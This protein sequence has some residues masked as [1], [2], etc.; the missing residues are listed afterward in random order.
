LRC[1]GPRP[2]TELLAEA[3]P[4]DAHRILAG[5][6]PVLCTTDEAELA[7]VAGATAGNR[8]YVAAMTATDPYL[9]VIGAG[10]HPELVALATTMVRRCGLGLGHGRRRM[11]RYTPPAGW[12][13][14]R[15]P[16]T[17]SWYHPEF[18]RS[19]IALHVADA[20]PVRA[21]AAE[22]IDRQLFLRPP[23]RILPGTTL[24][25]EPVTTGTLAGSKRVAAYEHYGRRVVITSV[26]LSDDQ[27]LYLFT[28]EHPPGDTHGSATLES[29][30]STVHPIATT[31]E[32]EHGVFAFWGE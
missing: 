16:S 25:P 17:S 2:I 12:H 32:S 21:G 10:S 18:P 22:T 8:T 27:F 9:S 19:R 20:R 30:L 7:I 28:L 11:F 14:M 26:A 23:G 4:K 31:S 3:I 5:V 1:T 13:G 29:L 6:R 24:G 15:R